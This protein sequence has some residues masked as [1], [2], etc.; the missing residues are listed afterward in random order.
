MFY[1]NMINQVY[2]ID[3]LKMAVNES[4]NLYKVARLNK[5]ETNWLLARKK[6]LEVRK[7]LVLA[8][9]KFI[10]ENLERKTNNLTKY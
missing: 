5:D 2:F 9:K 3:T 6:K 1:I 7:L 4:D 10:K 8:K